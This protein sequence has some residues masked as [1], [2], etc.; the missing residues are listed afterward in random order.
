MSAREK[1]LAAPLK[2][3]AAGRTGHPADAGKTDAGAPDSRAV[4]EEGH[5]GP[6]DN[7]ASAG[8][9]NAGLKGRTVRHM[10]QADDRKKAG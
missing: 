3:V 6:K 7:A 1:T 8:E 5:A 2:D 4:S 9:R 10:R